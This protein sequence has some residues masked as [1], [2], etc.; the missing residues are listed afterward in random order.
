MRIKERIRPFIRRINVGVLIAHVWKKEYGGPEK[1]LDYQKHVEHY[2]YAESFIT[3][4]EEHPHFRFVQALGFYLQYLFDAFWHYEEDELLK[5]CG[6]NEAERTLWGSNYTE[7]GT[8]LS[9]TV[10]KFVDELESTHL[11]KMLEEHNTGVRKYSE[12]MLQIFQD[13][14]V[15]RGFTNIKY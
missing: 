7:D 6:Y 10:Y 9:E 4:W 12:R 2:I 8:K 14:L 3:Y 5:L 15:A 13:E 11:K 1:A